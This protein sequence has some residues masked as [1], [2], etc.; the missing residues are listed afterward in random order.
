MRL[1]G[2]LNVFVQFFVA[3]C[4]LGCVDIAASG[5]MAVSRIEVES[6]RN[7]IKIAEWEILCSVNGQAQLHVEAQERI[8]SKQ[9]P[10]H[11]LCRSTYLHLAVAME[12]QDSWRYVP[13]LREIAEC[14][15][16]NNSNSGLPV[17]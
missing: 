4:G 6:L 7:L 10:Y 12:Y 16:T 2:L 15:S 9:M 13:D 17:R 8:L 3:S 5:N 14:R 1:E 11:Y